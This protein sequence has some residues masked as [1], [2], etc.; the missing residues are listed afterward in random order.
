[1]KSECRSLELARSTKFEVE[2]TA[3]VGSVSR[4]SGC[5]SKCHE[6]SE[7]TAPGD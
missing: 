5:F 3:D 7:L 4:L 6:K 1:V 2:M